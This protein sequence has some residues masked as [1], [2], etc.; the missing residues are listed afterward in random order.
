MVKDHEFIDEI[1]DD[2]I[3][4]FYIVAGICSFLLLAVILGKIDY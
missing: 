4:M 2:L 3:F 1:G